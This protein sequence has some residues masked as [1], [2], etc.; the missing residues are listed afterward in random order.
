MGST[1]TL[2]GTSG[3]KDMKIEWKK[4]EVK[5]EVHVDDTELVGIYVNP[6]NI[7]FRLVTYLQ[8]GNYPRLKPKS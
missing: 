8:V 6:V 3:I 7:I 4:N 2:E 5:F 1:S